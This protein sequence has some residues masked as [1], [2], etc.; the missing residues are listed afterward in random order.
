MLHMQRI[1]VCVHQ[2]P[3][4]L[5]CDNVCCAYSSPTRAT[6]AHIITGQCIPLRVLDS[7]QLDEVLIV[8]G[9]GGLE[10]ITCNYNM[11]VMAE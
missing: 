8:M 4:P 1:G 5:I 7:R 9:R 11:H 10:K 3:Y 2:V 6:I